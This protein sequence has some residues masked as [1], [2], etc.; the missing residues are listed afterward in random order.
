MKLL[1]AG[2]RLMKMCDFFADQGVFE[3]HSGAYGARKERR[4]AE[5]EPFFNP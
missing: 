3:Q 1:K 4:Y 5:K 2:L